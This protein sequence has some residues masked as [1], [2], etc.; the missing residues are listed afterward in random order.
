MPISQYTPD[1]AFDRSTEGWYEFYDTRPPS[2]ATMQYR[3][4]YRGREFREVTSNLS[5]T[6]TSTFDLQYSGAGGIGNTP[7]VWLFYYSAINGGLGNDTI[8][9]LD[10]VGPLEIRFLI[11]TR[12]AELG[13]TV[14]LAG[15]E[16][17]AGASDLLMGDEGNDT[18]YG[19]GGNDVLMGGADDD[20]VGGGDDDDYLTGDGGDDLLSGGEGTDTAE[21]Q[22]DLRNYIV[23]FVTNAITVT[24]ARTDS[25]DGSDYVT[26]VETLIFGGISYT[27]AQL[28]NHNPTITS[29]GGVGTVIKTIAENST[30]VTVLTATDPDAGQ[31]IGFR[32]LL[33]FDGNTPFQ[34]LNGNELHFIVAPN[35][36]ATDQTSLNP[37]YGV[38]IEAFDQLG[39]TDAQVIEIHITNVTPE[40][41]TGTS[42]ANT[43]TGGSDI[44]KIFGL[45]G[46][47]TLSGLGGNDILTGG[48][49]NDIL[50]GGT[51]RD[52]MTGGTGLDDFDFNSISE[53]GKASTTSDIIRDFTH[54]QDDI[55]LSTI[56]ASTKSAGNQN[57]KFISGAA[58]HKIAGELHYR[59]EGTT[60]TIVEGDTNGDGK[61]D[62]MI[63]LAGHKV[64]TGG[65][66]VL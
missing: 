60:K 63:E 10:D 9:G 42:A 46:N 20:Y 55:D 25:P 11:M 54:L 62:F 16:L 17:Y 5:E 1:Y 21:W 12:A 32:I 38:M 31:M 14:A 64:L 37:D 53:T 47:D 33:D 23:T 39:G 61:A 34:I 40:T 30:L 52:I 6:L 58:F 22:G 57:F 48:L 8:T 50:T 19:L 24:D 18:L 27:Q 43:L 59:F 15:A 51:G 56:D 44:D 41:L 29:D 2:G 28:M 13:A 3:W 26:G 45:A 36:E 66:F 65:D 4:S 7:R 49:G 35:Y